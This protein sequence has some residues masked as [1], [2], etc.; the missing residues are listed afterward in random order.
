MKRLSKTPYS[1][2]IDCHIVD[3]CN[4]NC[5]GCNHFSPIAEKKFY[6]VELFE[7]N[8][9]MLEK[10]LSS[11]KYHDI[12]ILGGEPLLHPEVDEF[13]KVANKINLN[14]TFITNGILLT[15]D[16]V[17]RLGKIKLLI[18]QYPIKINYDKKLFYSNGV[19]KNLFQHYLLYSK[20][21]DKIESCGFI[22]YN[23]SCMSIDENGDLHY[24]G[25]TCFIKHLNKKYGYNYEVIKDKDYFNI[26]EHDFSARTILLNRQYPRPFCYY[27][28]EPDRLPWHVFNGKNEW[29]KYEQ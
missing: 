23:Q 7:K 27:C 17:D 10:H 15:Q 24:C 16:F 4:L 12:H 21:Q 25:R 28:R 6:S 1:I 3:H 9:R 13:I 11:Y 8:M 19:D 5:A 2:I 14:F 18:T 20:K 22:N 26:F 29:V